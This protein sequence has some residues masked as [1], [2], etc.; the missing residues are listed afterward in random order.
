M[1]FSI[2]AKLKEIGIVLDGLD[3]AMKNTF[4]QAVGSIAKSAQAEWIRLGQTRLNHRSEIYVTG[5]RQA[6]SFKANMQSGSVVYEVSLVGDQANAFED[7][8][9][10]FDMKASRPGWLGG[11]K[12]KQA[13][14]GSSYVVIPFSHSTGKDFSYTGKAAGVTPDLK[15]QLR[16]AVKKYAL[17]KAL[18]SAPGEIGVRT[19]PAGADVHTYL[20]GLQKTE[21]AQPSA[22][23]KGYTRTGQLNTFRVMSEKSPAS[24]WIHP[25]IEGAHLLQEVEK[26]VDDEMNRIVE[27]VLGK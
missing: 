18:T 2:E 19:I 11:A 8:M 23:G 13:K 5:L 26:F 10:P 22:A 14:D 3:E 21:Y 7:G 1:N 17:D 12:A 25:G 9:E 15:S 6:E 16:D 27:M 4:N 20:Q 24:S